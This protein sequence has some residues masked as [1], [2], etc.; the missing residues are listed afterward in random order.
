MRR[1]ATKGNR[2]KLQKKTCYLTNSRVR[3]LSFHKLVAQ[4]DAVKYRLV[5][6]NR[7]N[8]PGIRLRALMFRFPQLLLKKV[9]LSSRT[10]CPL[11]SKV[12]KKGVWP[13]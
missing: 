13:L 9:L 5:A 7:F 2:A 4:M 10:E 6:I 1:W 12:R 8:I 11:E 3:F